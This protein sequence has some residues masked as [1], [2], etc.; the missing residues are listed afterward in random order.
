MLPDVVKRR[1]L[2]LAIALLITIAIG[3]G[4]FVL[5]DGYSVFDAF[6]MALI[7]ITTVG[8]SEIQ[9]LS[10]AGRI[11]NTFLLFFG[12][13][14]V[15]Y[16]IGVM[17]QTII[18]LELSEFF[19]KRRIKRM[20]EKLN[21]H[22][23][24]CGFGRVGRS[25]AEELQ[26]TGS[27]FVVVDASQSKV[28][29][30][31][32]HGMLAVQADAKSDESLREVKIGRA[33]GLIASLSSDADN[34]FLILTAKELN[35]NLVVASRV[36]EEQSERKLMRAGANAIFRPYNITGHRLAQALLRP[37]LFEFLDFSTSNVDIGQNIGM[38]QIRVAESSPLAGQSLM[39]MQL[40]RDLD[41]IVLAIR[42]SDGQMLFNPPAN[43]VV[44]GA[45]HMI[46][47]GNIDDM[48]KL[49]ERMEGVRR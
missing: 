9:P 20:I 33:R 39:E 48:Q 18:E 40:R 5:I 17:T 46:V 14:V 13:G 27:Q 12:V 1:I 15:F 44:N 45:D 7:T 29:L 34:L 30:A 38:E 10:R 3:T 31:I 35:P 6:Y 16:G 2:T 47:M 41:V 37:Y 23:I 4:G 26:R 32:K 21:G 25:A 36:N 28:E 49:T 19:G 24:V 22:H 42:R 11:F 8:Y 43:A